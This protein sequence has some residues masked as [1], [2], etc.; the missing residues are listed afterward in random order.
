MY[1][2]FNSRMLMLHPNDDE[3]ELT[4]YSFAE[5]DK[6]TSFDFRVPRSETRLDQNF[7]YFFKLSLVGHNDQVIGCASSADRMQWL[8]IF[9]LITKVQEYGIDGVKFN[10]FSYEKYYK[11]QRRQLEKP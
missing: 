7:T 2:N 3:K 5:V 10:L 6:A 11:R 4:K 1:A 8:R 9:N